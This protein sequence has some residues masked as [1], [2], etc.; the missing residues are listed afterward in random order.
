MHDGHNDP[1]LCQD[2]YGVPA[3]PIKVKKKVLVPI[4]SVVPFHSVAIYV[5]Q[6]ISKIRPRKRKEKN[7]RTSGSHADSNAS[8]PAFES[9]ATSRAAFGAPLAPEAL[10]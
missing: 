9:S 6:E 2:L 1:G 8:Q 7:A 10:H 4:P 3:L 5:C